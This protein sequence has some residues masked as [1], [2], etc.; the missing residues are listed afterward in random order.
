MRTL[1][2]PSSGCALRRSTTGSIRRSQSPAYSVSSGFATRWR[3][4]AAGCA[5]GSTRCDGAR[6]ARG[7]PRSG[8]P[9]A[10]IAAFARSRRVRLARA[11]AGRTGGAVAD[12]HSLSREH[13]TRPL[14]K[15]LWNY[16][17]PGRIVRPPRSV[18][19][20]LRREHR[21]NCAL[22]PSVSPRTEN[23]MV[24]PGAS[25]PLSRYGTVG[26]QQSR[27]NGRLLAK[28]LSPYEIVFTQRLLCALYE[29]GDKI[30]VGGPLS[31]KL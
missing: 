31:R 6:C 23:R 1:G 24:R 29:A 13:G 22:R 28:T 21:P 9:R 15:E 4:T 30:V 16:S 26:G 17:R 5:G 25:E 19:S 12:S 18:A 2:R 27:Q 20:Q 11:A 10:I 8:R 7:F 14:P 3:S